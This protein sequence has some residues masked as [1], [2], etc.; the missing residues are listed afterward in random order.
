MVERDGNARC[1]GERVS[2]E[3]DWPAILAS[4]GIDEAVVVRGKAAAARMSAA[5]ASISH[6]P[7]DGMIP[8]DL[9]VSLMA[10]RKA[11]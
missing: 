4:Q 1:G 6:E 10:R 8:A 2:G 5:A 11:Q 7:A 3:V 9:V